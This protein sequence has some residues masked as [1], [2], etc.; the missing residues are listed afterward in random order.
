MYVGE[1]YRLWS[2]LVIGVWV[3]VSF[4]SCLFYNENDMKKEEKKQKTQEKFINMTVDV[5]SIVT[6]LSSY[7]V[8][9]PI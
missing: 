7:S 1:S 5:I 4:V 3:L 8:S 9:S 2:C 6:F